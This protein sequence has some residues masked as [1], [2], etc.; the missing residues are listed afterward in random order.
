MILHQY[1]YN[2]NLRHN[3]NRAKRVSIQQFEKLSDFRLVA[4][5]KFYQIE[6]FIFEAYEDSSCKCTETLF[7]LKH[8]GFHIPCSHL[9]FKGASIPIFQKNM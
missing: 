1:N 8:F 7:A 5:S 6:Y 3:F 4:K 2:R 9:I